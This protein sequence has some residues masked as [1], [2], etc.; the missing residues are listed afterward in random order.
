MTVV[1]FSVGPPLVGGIHIGLAATLVLLMNGKV[2]G[3]SG[4]V[5]RSF[6]AVPGDTAWRVFFLVGLV[7]GG[8]ATFTL[9]PASAHFGINVGWPLILLG[10]FLVG[11]GTRIGGGCTS[12]HGVCGA[13]RGSLRSIVATATFMTFGF[14]TLYFVRHV[15]GWSLGT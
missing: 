9:H 13:S 15:L 11:L 8:A 10:G 4:I 1:E 5:A 3:I 14:V 6:Q 2:A 7:I 12:G